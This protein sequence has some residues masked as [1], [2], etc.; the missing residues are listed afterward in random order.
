ML[1]A[2]CGHISVNQLRGGDL[3]SPR[4]SGSVCRVNAHSFLECPMITKETF[5]SVKEETVNADA[6]C[7]LMEL[8][9]AVLDEIGGGKS[10]AWAV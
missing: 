8:N 1:A 6:S 10:R 5:D 2:C 4:V 7:L 9:G 3:L